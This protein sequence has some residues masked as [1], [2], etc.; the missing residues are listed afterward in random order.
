MSLYPGLIDSAIVLPLRHAFD[1]SRS[2]LNIPAS[3]K[4]RGS[5]LQQRG[6]LDE[7]AWRGLVGGAERLL[8]MV[9]AD[10]FV[11]TPQPWAVVANRSEPESVDQRGRTKCTTSIYDR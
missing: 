4:L 9:F 11:S 7:R 5:R 8:V 2:S 3:N 1:I 6:L 10:D